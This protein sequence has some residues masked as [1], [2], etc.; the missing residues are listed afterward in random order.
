V[1]TGGP[2][3][4][5]EAY[6][7]VVLVAGGSGITYAL[8]L[9]DDLLAKHAA[10][11][12]RTRVVE[13]VWSVADPASLAA[14]LP[15]LAPLLRPRGAP[16]GQLSLRVRVHYTRAPRRAPIAPEDLP[17]GVTLL[18]GRPNYARVLEEACDSVAAA[19]GADSARGVGVTHCGPSELG[20]QI[21]AA[22]GKLS[23]KRWRDVGG[24]EV[25]G[26]TFGW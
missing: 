12:A 4:L 20:E 19:V 10:G 6:S 8:S 13:L 11:A 16:A 25:H 18:S 26:E 3:T 5:F 9:L 24:V 7:G 22:A 14:L 17:A 21:H 15:T 1:C 2:H 23:W